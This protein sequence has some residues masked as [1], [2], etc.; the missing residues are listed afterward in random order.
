VL[1]DSYAFF[2]EF[3]CSRLPALEHLTV[4]VNKGDGVSVLNELIGMMRATG[5]IRHFTIHFNGCSSSQILRYERAFL[6]PL[7]VKSTR[8]KVLSI[9]VEGKSRRIQ[10]C[11]R[12]RTDEFPKHKFTKHVCCAYKRLEV[13]VLG[14]E[15][16]EPLMKTLVEVQHIPFFHVNDY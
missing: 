3:V 9:Y 14:E 16:L 7:F 10:G 13:D 11:T 2:T 1:V 12:L 5:K 15:G 6:S 8:I 4:S